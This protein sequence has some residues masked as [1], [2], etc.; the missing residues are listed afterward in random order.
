MPRVATVVSFFLLLVAS[1]DEQEVEILPVKTSA[2]IAV[3]L[4]G[5]EHTVELS[6]LPQESAPDQSPAVRL[7]AALS[8]VDQDFE[9]KRCDFVADDGFRTS[10]QGEGCEPLDCGRSVDAFLVLDSRDLLWPAELGMRGC[11]HPRG[12]ARVELMAP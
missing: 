9:S 4:D 10:N 2:T 1:C 5:V 6:T 11:Y 3:V 12:L 7:S 8:F